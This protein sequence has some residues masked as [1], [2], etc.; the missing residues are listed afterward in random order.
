MSEMPPDAPKPPAMSLPARLLNVF[1][2]PGEVFDDVRASARCTANWLAPVLLACVI[3][4][5]S[6]IVVASQPAIQQQI[7]EQQE[8][9][10]E[11]QVQAGK[12]TREQADQQL[13]MMQKFV[14][15]TLMS[16]FGAAAAIV[17]SF[18]SLFGW[19]LVL[20]LAGLWFLKTRFNYM[21]AVEVVGLATM[22][23]VLGTIVKLLLQVNLSNPA[24]SPSLALAVKDFDPKNTLHLVL[25]GLNAFDIWRVVVMSVGLSRLAGSPFARA[26]VPVLGFWLLWSA[27][28]LALSVMAMKMAG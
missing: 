23:G 12:M 26:A 19:S 13:A 27:V 3:A 18:I 14:T 16:I 1:A 11:K 15:P 17:I 7:R 5:A 9:A 20:W 21:K 10:V 4:A 28:V 8:G 24:S 22:I 25:A 2:A 6:A